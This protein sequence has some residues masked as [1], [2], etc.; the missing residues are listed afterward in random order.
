MSLR[1]QRSSSD[2][3]LAGGRAYVPGDAGARWQASAWRGQLRA[4]SG[5]ALG[6]G[7]AIP[8]AIAA[9]YIVVFVVRLPHIVT[10]LYWDSDY[11]SGFT[12]PETLVKTGLNGHIVMASSGQ[13][14]SLWFGLLT[15]RLPLHR[16][17]WEIAPVAAFLAGVLTVG[18]TVWRVADRRAAVLA[19][20]IGAVASPLAL[21]FFLAGETHNS[22]YLCTALLGAY[23]V[24]LARGEGRALAIAVAVPPLV[25][26]VVGVCL[27]S[28]LL[29]AA[30][31]LIPLTVTALLAGLRRERRSRLIALSALATLAVA[32]PIAKL[33]SSIMNSLGYLTLRTPTQVAPLGELPARAELLFKGLKSLFN[34]YLGTEKP[35]TLHAELGIASD[36]VMCAALAALIVVG[37]ASVVRLIKSVL[38]KSSVQTPAQQARSLHVIYWVGSAVGACGAFWIVA[39]TGGGTNPHE[40]YYGT[41]IFSVAAVVPLLLS[42]RSPARWL[43]PVGASIYFAASLVGLTSDY[44][45]IAA[46]VARF[47]PGVTRIAQANHVTAGY[48]GWDEA[49]SFTWNTHGRVT[50]RPLMECANPEGASVCPFY[51]ASV[52]SWYTPRQRHTFLLV[53]SEEPWISSLP[54]GLGKPL[55]VYTL[56]AMRMYIY[57]YD[58]ASRLGP[59]ED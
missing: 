4:L 49:S 26:V 19:V 21:A 47:A 39:E 18:W 29:L 24:W 23:L 55:A 36:I 33:T 2:A 58:I 50:V 57:P 16:Q 22:A 9:A 20:L 6:P 13:W 35:G 40:A 53:N 17:L 10:E 42:V 31:G 11:A 38:Q 25:G 51:M 14:V 1:E 32:I 30:T 27:A 28:D 41:V 8:L 48:G 45:N 15:G 52:P 43:I 56:G 59:S 12:I 34:G 5:G 3:N 37:T 44:T 54:S 46:A 7:W